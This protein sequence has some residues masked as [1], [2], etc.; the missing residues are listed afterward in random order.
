MT[1]GGRQRAGIL[2]FA[3]AVVAL[4]GMAAPA[5]A[6]PISTSAVLL[7]VGP[8]RVTAKVEL[9]LDELSVSRDEVLTSQTATVPSTLLVLRRYVQA[10][11]KAT[12][13]TR[14]A[15][16]T[17]VSGGRIEL[18]DGIDHLVLDA[19]FRPHSGW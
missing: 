15:W 1:V 3:V 16:T 18:I 13:S 11:M 14:R 5:Q 4:L 7:D 8:E 9:P 12:D 10:H 2:L 6:H 19:T 17:T